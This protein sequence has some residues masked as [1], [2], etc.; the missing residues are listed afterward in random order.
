MA[1]VLISVCG[2]YGNI[3]YY[4]QCE[5]GIE[6]IKRN[7]QYCVDNELPYILKLANGTEIFRFHSVRVY[8]VVEIHESVNV[9]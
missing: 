1:E 7:L 5:D 4:F 3:G 2:D 6:S 9:I 8:S